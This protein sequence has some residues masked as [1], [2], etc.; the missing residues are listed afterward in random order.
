MHQKKFK[1]FILGL[2]CIASTNSFA[3]ISTT[4]KDRQW[5][6]LEYKFIIKPHETVQKCVAGGSIMW[7]ICSGLG[8]AAFD[9]IEGLRVLKQSIFGKGFLTFVLGSPVVGGLAIYMYRQQLWYNAF[10]KLVEKWPKYKQY[11]PKEF[12]EALDELYEQYGQDPE[13]LP[14][15]KAIKIVKII[16]EAVRNKNPKKYYRMGMHTRI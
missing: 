2:V 3:G 12:H 9:N 14:K 13:T 15:K 5:D 10:K 1:L 16:R 8:I 4:F 6:F 7:G 11:T